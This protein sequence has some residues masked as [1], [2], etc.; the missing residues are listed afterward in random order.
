MFRY[1]SIMFVVI[2]MAVSQAA[3]IEREKPLPKDLPPYGPLKPFRAPQ[4][5]PRKLSNGLTLW[6]VPAHEFPK[7]SFAIAIRGGMAADPQGR[8]GLSRLMVDTLDQGTKT[9]TARDIAEQVQA[10]G[11]D[12]SGHAD[13]DYLVLATSVLSAKTD[14]GLA[15]LADILQNATFPDNEVTLAKRNA[16]DELRQ[17]E[18]S[19]SFVASRALAKAIFGPHPYSVISPTQD[20]IAKTTAAE[21]RQE[22]ARRFRP[23]ETLVVAVGDFQP[24]NFTASMEKVL[25]KW[26]APQAAPV[27]SVGK[28]THPWSHDV[29]FASRPGSVQTMIALGSLG[30]REQDPDYAAGQVAN[31]IYGGMFGSRLTLNIRED[32]GYTYTPGSFLRPRSEATVFQ[33]WA[34]VRNEVTGAALNEINY[35]LNRMATTTPSNEE[36]THAQRYLVGNK[37]IELQAQEAVARE[38]A[39]LWVF[40]LPP[41]EVGGESEK[42]LAVTAKDVEAAGVKYFPASRQ[43]MVA[44]GEEKV[45]QEQLAPLGLI[46]KPAP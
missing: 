2:L 34:P 31:A 38:L 26:V 11:G 10:A 9:R 30:P 25:G 16:A 42:I 46:V 43:T 35:E 4:V 40:G 28:P 45:I 37:A 3:A 33:T 8:P 32:K 23:D 39:R 21:L 18:S 17:Q 6:L 29:L 20:S 14:A 19:P 36:V 13:A 24:E 7:V 27:S 22:Y 44:V 41:E 12:L 5:A 15:V 1:A